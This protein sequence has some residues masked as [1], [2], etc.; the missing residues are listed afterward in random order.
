MASNAMVH[1]EK[2]ASYKWCY[3]SAVVAFTLFV[4]LLTSDCQSSNT[5][6]A[7]MRPMHWDHHPHEDR[8][9]PHGDHDRHH[10]WDHHTHGHHKE[11]ET[12]GRHPPPPEEKWRHHHHPVDGEDAWK[13]HHHNH[14]HY[15]SIR[16]RSSPSDSN[17]AP[18]H[19]HHHP[20][21]HKG[22][23]NDNDQ[24]HLDLIEETFESIV[25]EYSWLTEWEDEV[26][27][28]IAMPDYQD[29]VWMVED[30]L[31]D[32]TQEDYEDDNLFDNAADEWMGEEDETVDF[33]QED[34][35]DDDVFVD[36]LFHDDKFDRVPVV[37]NDDIFSS[38]DKQTIVE[39]AAPTS[40]WPKDQYTPQEEGNED[41]ENKINDSV[42]TELEEEVM[43][44][45][46]AESVVRMEKEPFTAAVMEEEEGGH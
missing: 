8:H 30:E 26:G 3:G 33:I 6:D 10:D 7:Y 2:K 27:P 4:F 37:Y 5:E 35:E 42:I 36:D 1:V 34:Y 39:E 17:D 45:G 32:W 13:G 31:V 41:T 14:H 19:N 16:G 12:W 29:G 20:K 28:E 11:G 24:E 44:A 15:K 22:H 23:H 25:D 18:W 38:E 43:H 46:M 40:S 21:H 9:Q